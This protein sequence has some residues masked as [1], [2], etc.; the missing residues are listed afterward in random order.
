MVIKII[1]TLEANGVQTVNTSP[2]NLLKEVLQDMLSPQ[3]IYQ[4]DHESSHF[5]D[6]QM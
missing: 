4:N 5:L 6:S 3:Q 2:Q 1:F